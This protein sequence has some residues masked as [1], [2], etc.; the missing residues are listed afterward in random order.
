[1]YVLRMFCV[2][3][4]VHIV[5]LLDVY[6]I[7]Q[8]KRKKTAGRRGQPATTSSIFAFSNSEESSLVGNEQ[9]QSL[10][11]EVAPAVT[12]QKVM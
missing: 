7:P 4:Y 5:C 12:G 9:R 11:R 2:H 1:M 6:Y 3:N 8:K 10:R